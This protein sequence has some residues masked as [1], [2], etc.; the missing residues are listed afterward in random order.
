MIWI[1]NHSNFQWGFLVL[2]KDVHLYVY[3]IY[4]KVWFVK[5]I[6]FVKVKESNRINEKDNEI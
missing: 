5:K 2:L 3:H 6:L 4:H 1:V